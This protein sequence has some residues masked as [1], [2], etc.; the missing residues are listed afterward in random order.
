VMTLEGNLY[1]DLSGRVPDIALAEGA[2]EVVAAGRMV[3]TQ[4]RN[5]GDHE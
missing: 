4:G 5:S 1:A 3:A 2:R